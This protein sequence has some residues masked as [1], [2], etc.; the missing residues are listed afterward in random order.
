[1]AGSIE[2]AKQVQNYCDKDTKNGAQAHFLGAIVFSIS[3]WLGKRAQ[4]PK[5]ETLS[6]QLRYS[7]RSDNGC[8][9][10]TCI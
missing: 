1:M 10:R 9:R 6:T 5:I 2:L 4:T 3:A 8:P 7:A